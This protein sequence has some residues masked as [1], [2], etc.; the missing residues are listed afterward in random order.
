MIFGGDAERVSK[1]RSEETQPVTPK[2]IETESQHDSEGF[3]WL[4]ERGK[5]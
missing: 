2:L 4:N 1:L 5:F 3:G